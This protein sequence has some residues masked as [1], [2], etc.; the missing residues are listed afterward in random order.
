MLNA[1]TTS[2]QRFL[3]SAPRLHVDTVQAQKPATYSSLLALS[4]ENENYLKIAYAK[5]DESN[6]DPPNDSSNISTLELPNPL[7]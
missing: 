5:N 6:I 4:E 3:P 2:L 7:Q 1:T